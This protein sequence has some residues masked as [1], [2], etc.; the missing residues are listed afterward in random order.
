VSKAERRVIPSAPRLG[1]VIR[2]AAEDLY[3]N[4]VRLIAANALWGISLLGIVFV[5]SGGLILAPLSV[6]MVPLTMGLMRMATTVVRRRRMF[7]SDFVE[8][9]RHRFLPLLAIGLAQLL[10]T[11]LAAAD[12]VIGFQLPGVVGPVV[13]IGGAYT[14]AAI[15]LLAITTWPLLLDPERDSEPIRSILRLGFLLAV[16]HP[17]RLGALAAVLAIFLVLST[18]LVA[19]LVTI[20]GALTML[21]AAHYVL[22]A[23]DRLEGRATV[24]V[25]D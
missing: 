19:A 9:M 7:W 10:L 13:V 5:V 1:S 2:A 3:F 21:V 12:V 24:E 6:L 25:S 14:L 11:A 22:P 18:A 4:S 16:A 15:W 8:G 23:A 20:S 17:A